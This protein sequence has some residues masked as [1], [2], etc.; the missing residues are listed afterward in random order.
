M[1]NKFDSLIKVEGT[2][3]EGYLKQNA[4]LFPGF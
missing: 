4:G 2:I 1:C 3:R